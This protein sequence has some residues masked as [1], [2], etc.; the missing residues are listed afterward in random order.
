M[1]HKSGN[2]NIFFLVHLKVCYL[3]DWKYY[4]LCVYLKGAL[5]SNKDLNEYVYISVD[6]DQRDMSLEYET[7]VRTLT[8][9]GIFFRTTPS[10]GVRPNV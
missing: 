9:P 7:E 1:C 8:L 2:L 3:V 5:I 10:I 4:R 6:K